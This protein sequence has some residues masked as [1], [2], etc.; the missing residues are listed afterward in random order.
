MQN[1]FEMWLL[2]LGISVIVKQFI[3]QKYITNKKI[4]FL[5]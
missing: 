2:E 5:L 4:T 3:M 1:R